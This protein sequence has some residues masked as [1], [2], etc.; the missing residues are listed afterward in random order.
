MAFNDVFHQFTPNQRN[1]GRNISFV[2]KYVVQ[3]G[4]NDGKN[5]LQVGLLFNSDIV[6]IEE[7]PD[8][9]ITSH[10]FRTLVSVEETFQAMFSQGLSE[11]IPGQLLANP[12]AISSLD[13]T[14]LE[15]KA[16]I[17]GPGGVW[18]FVNCGPKNPIVNVEKDVA[19]LPIQQ[20]WFLPCRSPFQRRCL[21]LN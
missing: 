12:L 17:I 2:R 6:F 9:E 3:G 10:G 7:S 15:L 19:L 21:A 5:A 11:I 16:A 20:S 1:A 14:D 8:P 18:S 4:L 13:Y